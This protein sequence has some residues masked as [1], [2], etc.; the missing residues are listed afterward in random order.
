MKS[1]KNILL[2]LAIVFLQGFVFYGPISTLYRESRGISLYEIFLIESISWILMLLLEIP[3]GHF[4]DRFGYK[5]TLVVVNGVFFL[6]KIV[7]FT[8]GSFNDFLLERI[9]LSV[10]F[11]GFSGCDAALLHASSD[12]EHLDKVFGLYSAAGTAGFLIASTL[13]SL[14]IS[15]PL[16]AAS[17]DRTGFYT[18][19]PYGLAFV[20][21]WFLKEVTHDGQVKAPSI[22]ESIK[23]AFQ[24]PAVL[25][26]V[27]AV[28]LGREIFQSVTVFLNQGQYLRSGIDVRW[29]GLL[30]VLMQGGKLLA[31]R[32]HVYSQKLGGRRSVKLMLLWITLSCLL[33]Y[34]SQSAVL[35]ILGIFSISVA[36]A[37]LEPIAMTLEN[38]ALDNIDRATVLSV[39]AM[40]GE[41]FAAGINPLI[42]HA[43]SNSLESA[44]LLCAGLGV[45]A[46]GIFSISSIAQKE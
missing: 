33:L 40:I 17:I 5:K 32:S 31:A 1:R 23:K 4:S 11:A 42:G 37:I 38:K 13:S 27:I 43:A 39:Y 9:M 30:L 19:F 14:M 20:L 3:W 24:L 8:A 10:V 21:S 29:F 45:T 7:F 22:R 28:S 35:S 26:L 18:I 2:M 6:S 44:L 25:G 15:S 16:D 12:E 41:L 36:M 34:F 46:V